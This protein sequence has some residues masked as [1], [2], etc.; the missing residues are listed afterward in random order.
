M[1]NPEARPRRRRIAAVL[2]ITALFL[3]GGG[4]AY[5]YWTTSGSGSGTVTAGSPQ[6]VTIT[7]GL[8]TGSLVPGGAG[9]TINGTI[10]NPG[11][12]AVYVAT[13]APTVTGATDSKGQPVA[14]NLADLSFSSPSLVIN[15]DIAAGRS[16]SWT[17]TL[18]L[19]DTT[20]NQDACKGATIAISYAATPN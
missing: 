5:A 16:V 12:T 9:L 6:S 10:N 8:V 1:R 14:C 2:I 3:G 13:L 19:A 20:L 15:T 7:Q 11:S 17:E 4:A 18:T